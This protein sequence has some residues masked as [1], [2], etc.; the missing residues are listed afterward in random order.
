L[1]LKDGFTA[2]E[3]ES[4]RI[5]WVQETRQERQDDRFIM[6]WLDRCF[7]ADHSVRF[8]EVNAAFRKYIHPAAFLV[9]MARSA[10]GGSGK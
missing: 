2:S 7:A 3:L 1:A 9:V 4:A 5:L 6:R 8:D 10:I